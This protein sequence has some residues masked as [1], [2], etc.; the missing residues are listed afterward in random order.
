MILNYY[1]DLVFQ[2]SELFL[3]KD[4]G[5]VATVLGRLH[6]KSVVHLVCCNTVNPDLDRFDGNEVFQARKQLRFLPARVDFLKNLRACRF[7]WQRRGTFSVLVL[8]PF[9]PPS[10][11][12][13]ARLFLALNPKARVIMKLDANLAHLERMQ[14]A[15]E[16][17]SMMPFRQHAFYRR[18]LRLADLV[19]YET[20]HVGRLLKERNFLGLGTP[21]KFIN[22][23]NGVSARRIAL[24]AAPE[25]APQVP[26]NVIVFSG[27]L[28]APQK[29]VELIFRS[30][31][32]P[33]GWKIRFLGNVD[34]AFQEVIDSYRRNDERFDE[35]YVFAGQVT[36]KADYYRQLANGR[37]L[38]LCSDWEGFPMVYSEAH[39]FGLYIV[40]TDV[41]GAA[42]ATDDGRLGTVIPTNEPAAL[43]DALRRVC[44]ELDLDTA[45]VAARDYGRRHFVWE[46]SLRAPAIERLFQAT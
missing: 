18:L 21:E 38:L 13:I 35:K 19:I 11:Y 20:R 10:D 1:N 17:S 33:R 22:V 2:P 45:I 27:R 6:G 40:T 4:F 15:H 8:F 3:S 28:S 12:L 41:S 36:N 30:D 37:V 39:Y 43:R 31:P 14:S 42:E 7:L 26:D 32:V 24:T 34:A 44:T 23:Y 5:E 25:G 29:N 9:C 16:S 46:D